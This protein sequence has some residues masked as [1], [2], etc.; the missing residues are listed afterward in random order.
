MSLIS[1]IGVALWGDRWLSPLAR[2]V[3][4]DERTVR[5]WARGRRDPPPGVLREL[6]VLLAAHATTCRDLA[7]EIAKQTDST[8]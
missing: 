8:S 4:V 2:A 1:R 6:A 3:R 7:D 5:A